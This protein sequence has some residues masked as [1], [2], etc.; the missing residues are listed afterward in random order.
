MQ[1]LLEAIC[2]GLN[3]RYVAVDGDAHTICV[4]DRKTGKHFDIVVKEAEE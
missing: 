4:K 1:E 3:N 2:I